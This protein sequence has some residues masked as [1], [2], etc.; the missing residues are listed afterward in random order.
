MQPLFIFFR[1]S[2]WLEFSLHLYAI[3]S[4]HDTHLKTKQLHI[5]PIACTCNSFPI[6]LNVQFIFSG[7]LQQSFIE[8]LLNIRCGKDGSDSDDDSEG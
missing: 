7:S 3:G 5:F 1:G 2:E 6:D 8:Y 4:G